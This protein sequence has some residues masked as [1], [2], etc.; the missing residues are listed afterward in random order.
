MTNDLKLFSISHK[1]ANV[2]VREKFALNDLEI[3][4]FTHK[5]K[6]VLSIHECIVLST[7]NRVEVYYVGTKDK[8]T[9][10]LKVLCA[11]KCLVPSEKYYKYIE[12]KEATDAIKHLFCTGIGLNSRLLGDLQIYGQ[13]KS[14]YH[15]AKDE[16]MCG[17]Y[18]HRLM[19]TFF[20]FHKRVIN[21]TDFKEGITSNSYSTANLIHKES[22][23]ATDTKILIIGTGEMGSDICQ[24]LHKLGTKNV[25]ITNRTTSKA[26]EISYL[27]GFEFLDYATHLLNLS[28]FDI[29]ISCAHHENVVYKSEHFKANPPKLIVD[30]C[31]PRTVDAKIIKLGSKLL[32]VD[33]LGLQIDYTISVRK[34]SIPK[35]EELINEEIDAFTSWLSETSF[36]PT[37][38]QFKKALEELRLESLA[39]LKK[40]L[41]TSE[42]EAVN[43]VSNKMIQKI[44][45]LPTLQLKEAC[46]KGNVAT[47]NDALKS[48]FSLEEHPVLT[49][50][51]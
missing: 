36:T 25:W 24:Y 15:L 23:R 35:V 14:A 49:T 26:K 5:L 44:I 32:N 6:E 38:K 21:E 46:K 29:V 8:T 12:S 51:I 9:E 50:K 48:L 11:F 17:T 1:K 30:L 40:E 3:K 27:Y 33:D 43:R 19:H 37:V 22:K 31:T 47:L 28:D 45:Q 2:I 42:L 41:K 7:C 18:L 39:S 16:N 13:L 34:N 4:Q 20:H 10:I